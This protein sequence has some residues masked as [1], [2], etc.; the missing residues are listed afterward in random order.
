MTEHPIFAAL[1]LLP[2]VKSNC[3]IRST[4]E[5]KIPYSWIIKVK[6]KSNEMH[7]VHKIMTW[8][9]LSTNDHKISSRFIFYI[10]DK[11]PCM[12]NL[13]VSPVKTD[14]TSL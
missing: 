5:F 11:A 4:R 1:I 8:C 12:I 14:I 3:H 13:F 9:Q 6:I 7:L 10:Y 2:E